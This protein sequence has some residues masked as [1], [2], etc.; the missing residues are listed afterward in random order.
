MS[1]PAASGV[2]VAPATRHM[3]VSFH[4]ISFHNSLSIV[5]S[6]RYIHKQRLLSIYIPSLCLHLVSR[7]LSNTRNSVSLRELL[8]SDTAVPFS[9]SNRPLSPH[10]RAVSQHILTNFKSFSGYTNRWFGRVTIFHMANIHTSETHEHIPVYKPTKHGELYVRSTM[11][12]II[13]KFTFS[14]YHLNMN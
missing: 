1:S 9:R 7:T 4:F 5:V 8:S 6:S 2:R 3:T 13:N 12:T 10:K 11:F 14:E